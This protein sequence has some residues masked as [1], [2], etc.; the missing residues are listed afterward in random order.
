ML[1]D[2]R[3]EDY[4]FIGGDFNCTENEFFYPDN[5]EPHV[6]AQHAQQQLISSQGLVD[7]WEKMNTGSRQYMWS[8]IKENHVSL[9]H[10]DQ[11]YCSVHHF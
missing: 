3:S 8:H 6:A 11:F 9:A 1:G 10:L 4:I 5:A 2:C 7:E